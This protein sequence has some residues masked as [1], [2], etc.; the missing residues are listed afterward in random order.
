M[1]EYEG[2]KVSDI[3]ISE[4]EVLRV[5]FSCLLCV[6]ICSVMCDQQIFKTDAVL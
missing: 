2:T 6:A 5:P 1:I 3:E 4:V